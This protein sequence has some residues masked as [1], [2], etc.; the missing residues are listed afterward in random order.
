MIKHLRTHHLC[1]GIALT[2]TLRNISGSSSIVIV[3]RDFKS[4]IFG[5]NRCKLLTRCM[6]CDGV[7]I[8]LTCHNNHSAFLPGLVFNSCAMLSVISLSIMSPTDAPPS[9]PPCPGSMTIF[10]PPTVWHE[11]PS[12]RGIH[13]VRHKQREAPN[14]NPTI[15]HR[16]NLAPLFLHYTQTLANI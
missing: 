13:T 1:S 14:N 15:S 2:W 16:F 3:S 6:L 9:K 8:F 11:E 12:V 10:T 7:P 5:S 4:A